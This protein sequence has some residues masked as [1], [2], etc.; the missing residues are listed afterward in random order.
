MKLFD[1]DKIQLYKKALNVY[2]KQHKAIA[3]NVANAHDNSYRP[4][5]T[6]FS[7]QLQTALTEKLKKSDPRHF[8][9]NGPGEFPTLDKDKTR[10]TVDLNKEMGDLAVN[11]IRFDFVSRLLNRT[12]KS[13]N[14]S[15]TG[16][17]N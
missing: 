2:D 15:I 1:F 9:A 10:E 12:Y 13:L 5:K 4:V 17:T 14:T 16:K 7:D 11:Q 6:D 3:Q 8:D